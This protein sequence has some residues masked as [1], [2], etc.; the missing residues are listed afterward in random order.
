[1]IIDTQVIEIQASVHRCTATVDFMLE[2]RRPYPATINDETMYKHAKRV[3]EVLLGEPNVHL[4]PMSMGAEDFGFYAEKMAAAFFII[5]VKNDS[6]GSDVKNL[7]S[8]NFVMNEDALPIGAALHAAVAISFL[9]N[10]S[11]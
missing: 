8:P 1:M 4:L 11:L 3:G 2:N 5:G 9:K 7:H 10:H 6:L